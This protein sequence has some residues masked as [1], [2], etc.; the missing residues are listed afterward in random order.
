MP[1]FL[2]YIKFVNEYYKYVV[3]RFDFS[4]YIYITAEGY[5]VA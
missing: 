1:A 3:L 2:Q 4:L 5:I